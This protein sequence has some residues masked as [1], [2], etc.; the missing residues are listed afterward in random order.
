MGTPAATRRSQQGVY[1]SPLFFFALG[2]GF[3]FCA[4]KCSWAG[5]LGIS[6]SQ[7]QLRLG[8]SGNAAPHQ[9]GQQTTAHFDAHPSVAHWGD[10]NAD[11][12][13][14]SMTSAQPSQL[15]CASSSALAFSYTTRVSADAGATR[16]ML[17]NMPLKKPR[18]P[19][20]LSSHGS[21]HNHEH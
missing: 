3:W 10:V 7:K 4:R 18:M 12:S 9:A 21:G 13:G 16:Y 2:F 14:T 11:T 5:I 17:G 6:P 20:V 15:P 19:S 1:R 8:K